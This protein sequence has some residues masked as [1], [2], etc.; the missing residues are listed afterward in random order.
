[1]KELL[2]KSICNTGEGVSENW[3]VCFVADMY[4]PDRG[5]HC[6]SSTRSQC[7]GREI[8]KGTRDGGRRTHQAGNPRGRADYGNQDVHTCRYM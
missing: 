2:K 5:D 6:W 3:V 8:Y 4:V 1:M 7:V